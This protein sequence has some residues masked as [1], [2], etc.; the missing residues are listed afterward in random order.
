MKI[1]VLLFLLFFTSIIESKI[2][3]VHLG[4]PVVT[5]PVV[6]PPVVTPPANSEENSDQEEDFNDYWMYTS[7]IL[8]T[9]IGLLITFTIG[10]FCY[11]CYINERK[12]VRR[13]DNRGGDSFGYDRRQ[14]PPPN[15]G[16]YDYERRI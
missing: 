11:Q 2:S 14:P 12:S 10:K 8:G 7:I 15:Y 13:F 9:A 16:N 1:Q 6:T 5:P 4:T 3:K